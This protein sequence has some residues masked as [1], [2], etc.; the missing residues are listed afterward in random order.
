MVKDRIGER[1][2]HFGCAPHEASASVSIA[3]PAPGDVEQF[4]VV[5]D[6]EDFEDVDSHAAMQQHGEDSLIPCEFCGKLQNFEHF[7]AHAQRCQ[8]RYEAGQIRSRA[9]VDDRH[10]HSR[11]PDMVAMRVVEMVRTAGKS[12]PGTHNTAREICNFDVAA[13]F[14]RKAKEFADNEKTDLEV[15]YHWTKEDNI[16]LIVENNLQAPGGVNGDGSSVAQAHGA[17][18]GRGIYAATDIAFGREYGR[19]APCALLCLALSGRAQ[20]S[21][22]NGDC[23]SAN[24]N[25]L[26]HGDMRV[27]GTSAQLL[28]VFMTNYEN[29]EAA[30]SAAVEVVD[31][32]RECLPLRL[33]T[34]T[35]TTNW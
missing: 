10:Q 23:L 29:D 25:S 17:V 33:Q 9:I 32:L 5:Q 1:C 6:F 35:P 12:L 13:T 28:P 2:Y 8:Q 21:A 34:I 31:Y 15:V 18:H 11:E 14:V 27:Y 22:K 20:D 19:G 16:N 7:E 4:E 30:R 26:Q 3:E 24:Y